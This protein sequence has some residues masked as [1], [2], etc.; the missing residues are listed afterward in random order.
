M[1]AGTANPETSIHG[2]RPSALA[3]LRDYFTSD[4][5][6]ALQT[7][8]GLLWLL[9]GALQFQ[10]FMYSHGFIAML[11]EMTAGQPSWLASSIGWAAKV[12]NGDLTVFNT[13]FA[14][15]QVTIGL[16]LL[17][18]RTVRPALALSLAWALLVWW[19]GEGFG[20]MFMLM[21][22][23]LTGAPGA[24]AVY[25]II[26]LIAWPNGRPGG[27][28]GLGGARI[29]W[30]ALWIVMAWLWLEPPSA[31][32]DA[33][34]SVMREAPS[35]MSWLSTIQLWAAKGAQGNGVAIAIALAFVSAAIGI[36]VAVGWHAKQFLILAIVLNLL[37]WVF[38]QGFGGIF[39]GGA[40]DPNAGIAFAVLAGAMW[41]LAS[42]GQAD[43][44]LA[45]KRR[46][47]GLV[48]G[49]A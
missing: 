4:S 3:R 48:A 18:R 33:T 32:P 42:V 26:A 40:T 43:R 36:A 23:P 44:Q 41:P 19:F 22:E 39:E 27:L 13:L 38:A 11:T 5:R 30:C 16:G 45:A 37:F 47:S 24:V 49:A 34:A 12:A 1:S 7:A 25:A 35:G 46:A 15:T 28:L 14:L 20:M 9:D 6:R 8:L 29:A 10:S 31:A 21:A 17:W 2:S